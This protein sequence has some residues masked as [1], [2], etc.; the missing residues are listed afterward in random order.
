VK[1]ICAALTRTIDEIEKLSQEMVSLYGC[2]RESHQFLGNTL[3]DFRKEAIAFNEYADTLIQRAS[4]MAQLIA[5]TLSFK[6]QETS[7]QQSTYMYKLT[8]ST[9]DDSKTVRIITLVTMVYLP[10]SFVAVSCAEL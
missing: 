8:N 5:D 4:S 7:K 6:N 10:F 3:E 2:T 9:V 1:P